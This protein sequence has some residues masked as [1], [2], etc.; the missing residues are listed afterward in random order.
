[1]ETETFVS[2]S[3]WLM[4]LFI[5]FCMFKFREKYTRL[6]MVITVIIWL[7][8]TYVITDIVWGIS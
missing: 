7:S 5:L 6:M 4:I 1:M 2:T 3:G 8:S